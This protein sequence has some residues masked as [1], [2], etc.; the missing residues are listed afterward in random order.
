VH[1]SISEIHNSSPVEDISKEIIARDR[2]RQLFPLKLEDF[3]VGF[4]HFAE[5]F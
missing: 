4:V 2:I 5:N 1:F 3:T